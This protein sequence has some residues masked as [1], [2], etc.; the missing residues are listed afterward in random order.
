MIFLTWSA[1]TD[2]KA[3]SERPRKPVRR[4]E[5]AIDLAYSTSRSLKTGI[6]GSKTFVALLMANVRRQLVSQDQGMEVLG[7]KNAYL[8]DLGARMLG[9]VETG[10][11]VGEASTI[12]MTYWAGNE[13]C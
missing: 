13:I 3:H 5:L 7:L 4:L 12:Y 8:S 2:W 1:F 9:P 11:E 6:A 10:R